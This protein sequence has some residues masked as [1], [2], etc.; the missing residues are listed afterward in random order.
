[1]AKKIKLYQLLLKLGAYRSLN[2]DL[3]QFKI[4]DSCFINMLSEEVAYMGDKKE[5]IKE[6]DSTIQKLQLLRDRAQLD[7]LLRD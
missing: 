6:I 2:Q 7:Y 4:S 3:Y 1:M 5:F